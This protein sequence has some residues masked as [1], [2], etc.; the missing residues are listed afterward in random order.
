MLFAELRMGWEVQEVQEGVQAVQLAVQLPSSPSPWRA[1]WGTQMG[2][3]GL[4]F[5]DLMTLQSAVAGQIILQH[6]ATAGTFWFQ[7]HNQI[8]EPALCHRGPVQG[9][10]LLA[11]TRRTI[12]V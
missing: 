4:Q 9:C 6:Y 11:E 10:S 2:V 12:R 8:I 5:N 1:R 7:A 3:A